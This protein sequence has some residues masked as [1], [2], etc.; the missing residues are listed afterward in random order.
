M[1][2]HVYVPNKVVPTGEVSGLIS[3]TVD[4]PVKVDSLVGLFL[5]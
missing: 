1:V 4:L 2:K 3:S 5:I